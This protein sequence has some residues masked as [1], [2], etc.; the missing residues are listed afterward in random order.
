MHGIATVHG[1]GEDDAVGA[2]GPAEGRAVEQVRAGGVRIQATWRCEIFALN[3]PGTRI[4]EAL[5]DDEAIA[6]ARAGHQRYRSGIRAVA[7][8]DQAARAPINVDL[9]LGQPG[10]VGAAHNE[11]RVDAPTPRR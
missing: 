7:Q 3:L 4:G 9:V 10:T 2:I 11:T 5:L 1:P 6:A 8:H